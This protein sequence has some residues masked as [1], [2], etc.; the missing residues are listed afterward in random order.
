MISKVLIEP[1]SNY[2]D[3]QPTSI[4]IL[5]YYGLQAPQVTFLL[6]L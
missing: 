3:E 2:D 4:I 1:C 5:Q 6:A